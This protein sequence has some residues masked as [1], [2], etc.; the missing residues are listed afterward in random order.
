MVCRGVRSEVESGVGGRF[1]SN[2]N[3][4]YRLV[5]GFGIDS[6]YGSSVGKGKNMELVWDWDY[7]LEVEL[8]LG[9]ESVLVK[10]S[11]EENVC[12]VVVV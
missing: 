2:A 9:I 8:V 11:R 6:R 12:D 4:I 3:K 10:V 5:S 7:D 1:V